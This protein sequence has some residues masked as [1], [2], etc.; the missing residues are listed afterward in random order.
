MASIDAAVKLALPPVPVK[1]STTGAPAHD[2]TLATDC[3][4]EFVSA[5]MPECDAATTKDQT[6]ALVRL[7]RLFEQWA[8]PNPV[9]MFCSGSFRLNVHS[10]RTDIDVLFMTT[11]AISRE[12]VFDGFVNVLRACT[13]VTNLLPVRGARVPVIGFTLGDQEF[14]VLTC[15]L[16]CRTLPPRA[17]VL[18]S[19]EW[20]NGLPEADVLAFNGPR[21]TEMVPKVAQVA[22]VAYADFQLALR[23]LRHWAKQRCVYGNK[24]GFL[25]GVNL[26]LMLCYVVQRAGAGARAPALVA[27]FFATFARW[28]SEDAISLDGHVDHA[29]PVWL[30]QWEWRGTCTDPFTVLTPCFP[31]FN[32]MAAATRFTARTLRAELQRAARI[33]ELLPTFGAAVWL[34]AL[35]EPL[36]EL[37]T[38]TRF[39]RVCAQAPD[40]REGT[41]WLGF[42]E[43]RVRHL[44]AY[45]AAAKLAIADF[46]FVPTWTEARDAVTHSVCRCAY[47]TAN[48][49]GKR[50]TFKVT[51]TLDVPLQYFVKQH[52]Q[53]SPLP[54]PH[55]ADVSVSFVYSRADV[56]PHV[57]DVGFAASD[58][59][60]VQ[61]MCDDAA[62]LAFKLGSAGGVAMY[63]DGVAHQ[64]PRGAMTQQ[65]FKRRNSSSAAVGPVTRMMLRIARPAI[66][67]PT[68]TA[69]RPVL[70]DGT[71]TPFD[72]YVGQCRHTA[73]GRVF[74]PGVFELPKDCVDVAAYIQARIHAQ[75]AFAAAV[76]ALF[77][78]QLACWCPLRPHTSRPMHSDLIALM[79]LDDASMHHRASCPVP[80]LIAEAARLHALPPVPAAAAAAPAVTKKRRR[81]G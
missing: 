57:L 50:R 44:I 60:A 61:R 15:H 80:V 24:S 26:A 31:R 4:R 9:H 21:V 67:L 40:T 76:R 68:T 33:C 55:G 39:L 1:V 62:A 19:Y 77:G 79:G 32:T 49:D 54:Q 48:D 17:D 25:G 70:R 64:R 34:A 27:Q 72:V 22:G 45:L 71:W 69:V 51:G 29:C 11:A 81:H 23:F 7:K 66:R 36:L 58:D 6:Q 52:V 13:D 74:E 41:M 20:M 3:L 73:A 35:C 46:R 47:I 16:A 37:R 10:A 28:P 65:P 12:A 78:K 42:I 63:R 30:S 43:S 56:P 75:P 14:D 2:S 59:A 5:R 38:C 8:A 18:A 53:L